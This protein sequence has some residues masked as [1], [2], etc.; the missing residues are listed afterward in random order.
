MKNL[1]RLIEKEKALR[2]KKHYDH[3]VQ[4]IAADMLYE[5]L[6]LP[7]WKFWL[8]YPYLRHLDIMN[9]IHKN[10]CGFKWDEE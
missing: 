4:I 7:K 3:D 5:M 9:R 1:E 8:R 2:G 6:E 10:C